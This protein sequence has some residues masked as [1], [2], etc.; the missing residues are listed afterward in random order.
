MSSS[1]PIFELTRRARAPADFS[2]LT[3]LLRQPPRRTVKAEAYDRMHPVTAGMVAGGAGGL[4]MLVTASRLLRLQP[5][6]LDLGAYVGSMVSR[7]AL[8]GME[9]Q[10]AGF[11]AALVLGATAV[12]WVP[13][14]RK[15][16]KKPKPAAVAAD[17]AAIRQQPRP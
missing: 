4:L 12:W 13:G 7:G 5:D 9:A 17:V 11:G 14:A 2:D 3:P 10:L 6:A 1:D 15:H 8:H 16:D